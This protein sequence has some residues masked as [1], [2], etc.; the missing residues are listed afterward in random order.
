MALRIGSLFFV[1]SACIVS[2]VTADITFLTADGA[3]VAHELVRGMPHIMRVKVTSDT[4]IKDD[5]IIDGLASYDTVQRGGVSTEIKAVNGVVSYSTVTDFHIMT[6]SEQPITIGPVRSAKT[7]N[8]LAPA[9]TINVVEASKSTSAERNVVRIVI[10]DKEYYE[11]E[12]IPVTVEFLYQDKLMDAQFT[13]SQAAMIRLDPVIKKSEG[14]GLCDGRTVSCITWVYDVVAT[15]AGNIVI[16]AVSVDYQAVVPSGHFFFTQRVEQRRTISAPAHLKV[17][18]LPK[19]VVADAVGSATLLKLDVKQQQVMA[20]EPINVTLAIAGDM[21]LFALKHILEGLPASCTWYESRIKYGVYKDQ[22]CKLV[23]FIVQVQEPGDVIVPAQ[24]LRVFNPITKKVEI[25]T[26]NEHVVRVLPLGS[27]IQSVDSPQ[28]E[29]AFAVSVLPSAVSPLRFMWLGFVCNVIACLMLAAAALRTYITLM[30]AHLR[31]YLAFVVLRRQIRKA[32]TLHHMYESLKQFAAARSCKSSVEVSADDMTQELAPYVT[33]E[34]AARLVQLVQQGEFAQNVADVQRE[35]RSIVGSSKHLLWLLLI[36]FSYVVSAH[37]VEDVAHAR[38]AQITAPSRAVFEQS[39]QAIA[40][41]NVLLPFAA[42]NFCLAFYGHLLNLMP[43]VYWQILYGL[44]LLVYV[45]L[46]WLRGWRLALWI[47]NCA[48][49]VWLSVSSPCIWQYKRVPQY[50]IVQS[51][52]GVRSGPSMHYGELMHLSQPS[53]VRLVVYGS[54]WSKIEAGHL[55][56]WV[57]SN[58]IAP[59]RLD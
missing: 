15:Q 30:V 26:T 19:S 22:S 18:P 9:R 37:S 48:M 33:E 35:I 57:E 10:P 46:L 23:E 31:K 2:A 20:G 21:P 53:E 43:L 24:Q 17:K 11:G 14:T 6:T 39:Q 41:E 7:G 42:K 25:L 58:H 38:A 5:I 49:F 28:A 16:P 36:S 3:Q 32:R 47:L 54:D 34:A 59:I 27:S 1:L 13:P 45:L 29:S 4:Q 40:T 50:A 55:K 12:R 44:L 52:T 8:E 51:R 56:G